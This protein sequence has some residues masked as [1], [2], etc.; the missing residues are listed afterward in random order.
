MMTKDQNAQ[1]WMN[2]MCDEI[3]AAAT[4]LGLSRSTCILHTKVALLRARQDGLR[5][6]A[7]ACK[8][9][10]ANR[11]MLKVHERLGRA[12]EPDE[13]GPDA[14]S[15]G[16]GFGQPDP[17]ERPGYDGHVVVIVAGRFL[18]DLTLDQAS[19]PERGIFLR[20]GFFGPLSREFLRGA[21]IVGFTMNG[22][23]VRYEAMPGERGFLTK[24]DWTMVRAGDPTTRRLL[25]AA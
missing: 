11:A 5:A 15:L 9:Q 10:I 3:P 12:P 4:R 24:P 19:R 23:E 20:P 6:E 17:E 18:M 2:R 14:W 1:A 22:S 13:W 8:V 25:E 7:L 21:T 16:I